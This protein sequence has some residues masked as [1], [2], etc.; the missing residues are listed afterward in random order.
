[1]KSYSLILSALCC[2]LLI[3][4]CGG[5]GSS[6]SSSNGSSSSQSTASE[7]DISW[8]YGSWRY[9][10]DDGIRQVITINSDR[11]VNY[12]MYDFTGKIKTNYNSGLVASQSY[13]SFS[14]DS[15]D[16]EDVLFI[17]NK[18]GK[19]A[20]SLYVDKRG[21]RLLTWDKKEPMEKEKAS[22]HDYEIQESKIEFMKDEVMTDSF[23][24][25]TIFMSRAYGDTLGYLIFSREG[26]SRILTNKVKGGDGKMHLIGNAYS[27][28]KAFSNEDSTSM[29]SLIEILCV[30]GETITLT[31]HATNNGYQN[32]EITIEAERRRNSTSVLQKYM[33]LPERYRPCEDFE[34]LLKH[35]GLDASFFDDEVPL[36][37]QDVIDSM[38]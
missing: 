22:T 35:L 18:G 14:V 32:N 12:A 23:L 5:R 37:S 3:C 17:G 16:G 34:A 33:I 11:S 1:M 19:V 25:S 6:S 15:I 26:V 20:I 27:I 31:L 9:I 29:E 2:F 28:R 36:E 4:T 38:G 21:R 10:T 13:N 7:D 24:H 30:S 8:I